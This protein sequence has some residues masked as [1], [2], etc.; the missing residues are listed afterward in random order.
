[1]QV[2]RS[3]HRYRWG[4]AGE[5]F[6]LLLPPKDFKHVQLVEPQVGESSNAQ[7]EKFLMANG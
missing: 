3:G 5:P 1:M 2:A 6:E 7:F 4:V